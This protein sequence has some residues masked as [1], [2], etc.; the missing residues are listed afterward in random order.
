MAASSKTIVDPEFGSLKYCVDAWDGLVPFTF[1]PS[2]TTHFTVQLRAPVSGP[3]EAQQAAYR[4][5]K[6]RYE[7]LWPS[8][9]QA[10]VE[11]CGDATTVD[12]L[13]ALLNPVVGLYMIEDF[14]DPQQAE[15]ELV[16]DLNRANEPG[17]ALF[18]RLHS[19]EIVEAVMAD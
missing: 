6:T 14:D 5:L 10:L 11:C 12:D 18:V 1:E 15:F 4:E 19:W 2:H 7:E 17:K 9:A 16:Y 13:A 3:T 8:I